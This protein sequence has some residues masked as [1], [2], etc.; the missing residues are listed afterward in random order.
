MKNILVTGGLGF[1]GSHFIK[2]LIREHPEYN[3][4]NLDKVTYCGNERNLDGV[5][6]HNYLYIGIE[7]EKAVRDILMKHNI[8][9]IVSFAA[10][11]HVDNSI[12]NPRAFLETDI[13]GLFNLVYNSMKCKVNR[14]ILLSSDEVYGSIRRSKKGE[15]R[16]DE[17]DETWNLAPNSPYAVSKACGDLLVKSYIH[18]Y[19]LPAILIR[20]C[21]NYGT[22]Q[23]AE[24]LVPITIARLL[25]GKKALLHGDGREVRE[26]IYV[27]DCCR[28][29]DL[30]LHEGEIGKIY[31]V[32]SGFRLTNI[33]VIQKI[34]SE[35]FGNVDYSEFIELVTNRPGNDKRYAIDSSF[36]KNT[37]GDYRLIDFREGLT[38]T[39]DWYR[40]NPWFWE[41]VDLDSNRYSEEYLR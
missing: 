39:V 13:L 2:R 33:S 35:L 10:E 1:I 41:G 32:G 23:Y 24:K 7:D 26:W 20:P 4:V 25:E 18:T 36:T 6:V 11:T 5:D 30:L 22:N 21:N 28:A 38:V 8:D 15:N 37:I 14:I 29:I 34:I 19:N 3:V 16:K 31:N 17:A 9:T 27:E 40:K 12:K